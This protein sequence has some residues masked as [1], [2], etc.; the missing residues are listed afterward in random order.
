MGTER[1]VHG[2]HR[3]HR[4]TEQ[5]NAGARFLRN[6]L[7]QR[8]AHLFDHRGNV[9]FAKTGRLAFEGLL[10]PQGLGERILSHAQMRHILFLSIS[11]IDMVDMIP[12]R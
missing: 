1:A 9:L 10:P 6:E 11:C 7:L 12:F 8:I 2:D 3:R 5:D 4:R